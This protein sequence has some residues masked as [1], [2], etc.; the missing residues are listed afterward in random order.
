MTREQKF[1]ELKATQKLRVLALA[2]SMAEK[3]WTKT[4]ENNDRWLKDQK[5]K[6]SK[7][8]LEMEKALNELY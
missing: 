5:W 8:G 7:V 6:M 2:N 3:K 1:N 4:Y